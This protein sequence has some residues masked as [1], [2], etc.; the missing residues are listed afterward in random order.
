MISTRQ[1][2][3]LVA[4]SLRSTTRSL[5]VLAPRRSV[6]VLR[7]AQ[8]L[9]AFSRSSSLFNTPQNEPK[10]ASGAKVEY[11]E[12]KKITEAPNDVSPRSRLARC[13]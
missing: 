11:N 6:V 10:W 8:Q 5:T 1:L 2:T 7:P 3:R 9:R 13:M 12:L 4:P